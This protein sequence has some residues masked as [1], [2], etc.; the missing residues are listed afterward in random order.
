[1][2]FGLESTRL[3]LKTTHAHKEALGYR[4]R[5]DPTL[6]PLPLAENGFLVREGRPALLQTRDANP[7]LAR[8]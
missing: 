8:M 1:M 7:N 5:C 3:L 2:G 4:Q 6:A